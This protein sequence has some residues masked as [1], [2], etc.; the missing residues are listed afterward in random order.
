MSKK[1]YNVNRE[2]NDAFYRYKMPAIIAKVEGQGNGIKTVIVNMVDIARALNREAIFP[3]KYFGIELG[4]QTQIDKKNERFIVNGSHDCDKLQEIL[5][6]YIKKFVLCQVCE[7]P[8]TT[9]TVVREDIIQTCMACG[10]K[11]KLRNMGHGLANFIVRQHKNAKIDNK[12]RKG[13]KGD[14]DA[15]TAV[16]NIY[17]GEGTETVTKPAKTNGVAKDEWDGNDEWSDDD[18]EDEE[19]QKLKNLSLR[20][21]KPSDMTGEQR[22]MAFEEYIQDLINDG[23]IDEM[24]AKEKIMQIVLK[25][26]YYDVKA[27]AP[28]VLFDKLFTTDEFAKT[29]KKYR[30]I[31]VYIN[32]NTDDTP[33]LKAMK[34]SL[35]AFEVYIEKFQDK[36]LDKSA[37]LLKF[38]YDVDILDEAAIIEWGEA[39]PSKKYVSKTLSATLKEK[40]KKLVEWLKTADTE[41]ESSSDDDEAPEFTDAKVGI[42][43]VKP[44]TPAAAAGGNDEEEESDIDDI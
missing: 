35:H 44:A 38:L 1:Q 5:D 7:N 30:G 9:L 3:T 27:K 25:A 8:E 19:T 28:F 15:K 37:S 13:D 29:C 10:N 41:S 34:Y 26:D 4:A 20:D 2:V 11:G 33:D 36:L 32:R 17:K 6:G 14:K 21:M 43:E 16:K 39:K 42:V 23:T 31:L 18:S 12:R 40:A 22:G 24:K